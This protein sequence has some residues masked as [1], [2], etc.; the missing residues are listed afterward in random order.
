MNETENI[1]PPYPRLGEIYRALAVAVDTKAG[2][3]I[4]DRLAREGE[5]DWSLLPTLCEEIV[6]RPLAKSVDP[7]F[8]EHVADSVGYLH[9]NYVKLVST[10]SLDGLNRDE[11][12]PLLVEHYF[13]PHALGLL[14][15]IK[16]CFG[17][18]DLMKLFDPDLHPVAVVLE[19]LDQGEERPLVRV[20]FPDATTADRVKFEM[21]R[22]WVAGTNLPNRQSIALFGAELSKRGG[23]Q[24]GKIRNLRIWLILARALAHLERDSPFLVRGFMRRQLLRGMPNVDVG[25]I[26]SSAVIKSGQRFSGLTMPAVSLYE[27]LKLTTRKDEGEQAKSRAELDEFERMTGRIDPEGRTRFHVE[28]LRG[29]WHALS[30][31]FDAA[32]PHYERAAELA[33][34]RA[35]DQQKR[36]VEESLVL[37]AHL[38]KRAVIKRLKHRAVAFGLLAAP[39]VDNVLEDWEMDH[40]NKCFHEVFPVEGRFP[41]VPSSDGQTTRLPLV[42]SNDDVSRIQPDPRNP[43]R[44]VSIRFADGQVLRRPQLQLFASNN[45]P[46]EVE[47]LL[48]KGA[49]VDQL[50]GSGSSALLC[51]IQTAISTG[52]RRVLNSLLARPH[53][54]ATLDS[55][56]TKKRLTPLLCAVELGEPD[57]VERLLAMGADADCRGNIVDETPLYSALTEMGKIRNPGMLYRNLLQSLQSNPDVV[58]RETLR[59]YNVPMAGVFGEG[60]ALARLREIPQN[61]EIL[62]TLALA[63]VKDKL[64]RHSIAKLTRIVELLLK[65]NANPN[66]P[67][68]YPAPGRTP[69]MLAAEINSG[70]VFGLMIRYGG[71]PFQSD[72]AGADCPRIAIGFS[73]A[74]VVGYMRNN[75]II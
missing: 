26:L 35:G 23:V 31:D 33:N 18:P 51:A 2:D 5:F 46:E 30:G 54:N 47:L 7:E 10:V 17:G 50:D 15:A 34:Y 11:A 55:V 37:A 60:R 9:A 25:H 74:E 71:D 12:L 64:R 58:T 75:R 57:V 28:W 4:V 59:R 69:L 62:E 65:H 6:E 73:S 66:A 24:A 1:L 3:R 32:L 43:D 68:K 72:A 63:T 20:A 38:H 13:T 48:S 27:S 19:W 52:D 67:H 61:A 16:K 42:I 44:V 21:V 70:T 53:S 36:I 49:P 39:R 14:D 40:L 45:R 22:K 29:R 8:A 41:E 56:T